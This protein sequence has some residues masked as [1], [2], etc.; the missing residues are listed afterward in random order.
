M[1]MA[2]RRNGS[3]LTWYDDGSVSQR[4]VPQ[5]SSPELLDSMWRLDKADPPRNKHDDSLRGARHLVGAAVS[6]TNGRV[7]YYFD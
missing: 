7:Y 1:A 6:K 4:T 2:V 3:V 5:D